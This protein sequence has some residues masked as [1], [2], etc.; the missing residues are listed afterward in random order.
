M[1]T[2]DKIL[3][4]SV[5]LFNKN[6]VVPVTTNHIAKELKISPGNLYFHFSNKEEIIRELFR[7]F[8]KESYALWKVKRG[9]KVISPL[10][11]IDQTFEL[12]WKYRFFHREM[13]YLRR[14]D[15]ELS[16]LWRD[17]LKKMM[18]L[19]GVTYR[20]WVK[21]GQMRAFKDKEEITYVFEV[22]L[23]TALTI[24]QFFE[25]AE[26]TPTRKTLE[27]GKKHLA[28]LLTEYAQGQTREDITSFLNTK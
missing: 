9:E 5:E 20:R 15:V 28:R 19:M 16:R 2:R 24:M 4:T 12:Y 14:K 6:G 1:K 17:H 23:A 25:S 21:N 22:V 10:D 11:M 3:L 8:G 26:K 7:R 13:Y 18:L 27:R